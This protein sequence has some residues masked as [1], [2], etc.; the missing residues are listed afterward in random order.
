[1][2]ASSFP[3]IEQWEVYW[4]R[5]AK[6]P[7]RPGPIEQ[8]EHNGKDALEATKRRFAHRPETEFEL[9]KVTITTERVDA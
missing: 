9:R 7:W 1:V 2:N 4:R 8:S 6:S 5:D 3:L